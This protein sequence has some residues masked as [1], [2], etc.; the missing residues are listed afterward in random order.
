MGIT[1]YCHRAVPNVFLGA[2]LLSTGVWNSEHF[3]NQ[4][5]DALFNQYA[6]AIDVASQKKVSAQIERLLLD[7]T[8]IIFAYNYDILG[9]SRSNIAGV[10]ITGISQVDL[11]KAGYRAR[12]S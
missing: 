3:K 9:A 5:Y 1:D 6:A 4:Q 12:D 11:R 8:P 7:E 10:V 2:P